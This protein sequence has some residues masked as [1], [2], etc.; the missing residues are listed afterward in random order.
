MSGL[1]HRRARVCAAALL[2]GVVTGCRRPAPATP[3]AALQTVERGP[4]RLTVA[5]TPREPL[6]GDVVRVD[7]TFEAPEDYVAALPSEGDFGPLGARQV[8]SPDP[9]PGASGLVWRRSFTLSPPVS[10]SLEI[11]ALTAKYGRRSGPTD[12]HPA[13]ESEL[14]SESLKLEVRSALTQADD[15]SRPRDITGALLPPRPP[16]PAW[17]WALLAAVILLATAGLW[18]AYR[19]WRRWSSRPPPPVLPEV[20]ALRALSELAAY[21]WFAKDEFREYYYRLTEIVR[22][23]VERKFCVAA[24]EMTTEEF[25]AMLARD[26]R[27]LPY[28]ADRLRDFLEACDFVKYAALTPRRDDAEGA[29]ATARAF[30]HATAASASRPAAAG[31]AAANPVSGGASGGPSS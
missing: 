11:P 7:V 22:S 9:R 19:A 1:H 14:V 18:A 27:T 6:V 29:L 31:D 16:R 26:R 28:D 21:D 10:G 8:D 30:I 20:W 5:A 15:P 12:T 4:L 2:V 17:Q 24:P 25:L 3:E 13:P 23:Y